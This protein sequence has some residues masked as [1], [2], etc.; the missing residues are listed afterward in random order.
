MTCYVKDLVREAETPRRRI[1]LTQLSPIF[2]HRSPS[3]HVNRSAVS[4]VSHGVLSISIL[5]E[6]SVELMVRVKLETIGVTESR[7]TR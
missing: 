3:I 4:P 1:G 2:R 5:L 6:F 7:W